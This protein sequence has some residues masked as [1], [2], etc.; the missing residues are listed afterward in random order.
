MRPGGTAARIR[1]RMRAA[2]PRLF[3]KAPRM[4]VTAS[5]EEE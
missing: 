4:S 1:R 5:K 2:A 3:H